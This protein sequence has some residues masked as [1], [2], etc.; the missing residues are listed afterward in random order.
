[1]NNKIDITSTV[2]EKGIDV[3]KSFLEKLVMPAI[4]ETGLLIKD[5][6][7]MLK[8]KTQVKMLNHAKVLCEKNG[9]NPKAISLKLLVPLLEYAGLE[10]D[11]LLQ[12]KWAVLLSNLVD[13]QQNIE[14]HVFPYIL[15][16]LSHKE[17]VVLEKVYEEKVERV[18]KANHDLEHFR[19]TKDERETLLKVQLLEIAQKIEF[20]KTK[21]ASAFD[22]IW[23][24]QKEKRKIENQTL[25][26]KYNESSILLIIQKAEEVPSDSLKDFELSNLIRLGLVKE[27]KEFYARSQTL[28]IPNDKDDFNDYTRVDLNVDVE[29]E[30][31]N[32]LTELGELFISA[33]KEKSKTAH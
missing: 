19:K 33:C 18:N 24:L 3:A 10:E 4:E 1:M 30:T 27:V 31:E 6:V 8:F 14:N 25:I 13:S 32:I 22:S 29:S 17:Y 15:S 12:N 2:L 21:K 5:Q 28:E 16:Q 9:I 26:L 11:E 20:E 23:E 7:T